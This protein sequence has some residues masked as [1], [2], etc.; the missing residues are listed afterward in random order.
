MAQ[1]PTTGITVSL[2]AQTL[3]VG[4]T[5]IGR[6]CTSDRI[7]KWAKYKPVCCFQT[8]AGDRNEICKAKYDNGDGSNVYE[9]HSNGD[10]GLAPGFMEAAESGSAW[11]E[12]IKEACSHDWVYQKPT[13]G[14]NF[15][16]RLGDF[17]G[18][19]TEAEPFITFATMQGGVWD[20]T[21]DTYMVNP[22]TD[23]EV[24]FRFNYRSKD[25]Y[26]NWVCA[27][28]IVG[29]YE[30]DFTRAYIICAVYR[31]YDSRFMN[32]VS[33]VDT[34]GDEGYILAPDGTPNDVYITYDI[35]P[36]GSANYKYNA[37]FAIVYHPEN[38]MTNRVCC[39]P[40]PTGTNAR[41]LPISFTLLENSALAGLK[42]DLETIRV[43]PGYATVA[44][45]GHRLLSDVT[46]DIGSGAK[47]RMLLNTGHISFRVT[48]ENTSESSFTYRLSNFSLR[49]SLYPD[50][51]K[52]AST[53]RSS[54]ASSVQSTVTI[55]A[56]GSTTVWI[57]FED[58]MSVP[59]SD[60]IEEVSLLLD[61]TYI[62]F[63][64]DM[65]IGPGSGFERL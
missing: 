49:T 10:Y 52:T 48:F 40:F 37:Y 18:Y 14:I 26:P 32:L 51:G 21:R 42:P 53:F 25:D 28:D 56:G 59:D 44:T 63:S 20:S 12:Q 43:Y 11:G 61:Q 15:P 19:D 1:L 50:S 4:T 9:N 24:T 22:L 60:T 45:S 27:D 2:V 62:I 38:L 31:D 46:D 54:D 57:I 55:P 17:R 13:G 41:T 35:T 8:V 7:N 39:L 58:A 23:H 3:G 65:F 33:S 6:L 36:L 29:A 47:Y 16:Y 34:A 30:I 64:C 5:D